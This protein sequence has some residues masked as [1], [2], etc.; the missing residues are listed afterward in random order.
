[1]THTLMLSLGAVPLLVLL[2]V[3]PRY[4]SPKSLEDSV[5]R[6]TPQEIA[7]AERRAREGDVQAQ[8]RMG[9]VYY[10]S[11][12]E[13]QQHPLAGEHA[14]KPPGGSHSER[15]KDAWKLKVAKQW[16]EKAAEQ[17]CVPAQ[18]Y[19]G[20][21]YSLLP[22][23]GLLGTLFSDPIEGVKWYS[24]AA[25]A[26]Y[27]PAMA[28]LGNFYE[29]PCCGL[30]TNLDL[31]EKWYSRA[32]DLGD[33]RAM[34]AWAE[35]LDKKGDRPRATKLYLKSAELGDSEA[36]FWIGGRYIEGIGVNKDSQQGVAWYE[37][38]A[39]QGYVY[40]ACGLVFCYATGTGVNKDLVTAL[41]WAHISYVFDA[42]TKC[43]ADEVSE[44]FK[45]TKA[46]SHKARKLAEQWFE[47]H[48]QFKEKLKE[49]RRWHRVTIP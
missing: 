46:Q 36:Q 1:M 8:L 3:L 30:E 7:N 49:S 45:P 40:G 13:P 15:D 9:L 43:D 19:L 31:A 42:L 21:V 32:S 18:Y 48:P 44:E 29:S 25:E 14:E 4:P 2:E 39:T 33:S 26:G 38:S 5:E 6:R 20:R 11:F 34:C 28:R 23:R 10:L 27:S 17:G 16:F 37:K 41:K 35:L 24:K 47:S 12:L 22:E